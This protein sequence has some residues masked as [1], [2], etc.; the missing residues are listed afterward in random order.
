MYPKAGAVRTGVFERI[1]GDFTQRC[2]L[3]YERQPRKAKLIDMAFEPLA[4]I[5]FGQIFTGRFGYWIM[6]VISM[7]LDCFLSIN[8][9]HKS[10]P[11]TFT[12]QGQIR[13]FSRLWYLR[14][15]LYR[16][17]RRLRVSTKRGCVE[18]RE[19]WNGRLLQKQRKPHR[20][21]L[22]A[23]CVKIRMAGQASA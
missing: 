14:N 20:R 2:L 3:L 5:G 19:K 10:S 11:A 1:S 18:L 6:M 17:V 12:G 15:R 7:I 16:F 9:C 23:N 8:F 4:Y 13:S 21:G 22:S